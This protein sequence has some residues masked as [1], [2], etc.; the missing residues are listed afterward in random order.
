MEASRAAS[1]EL[2]AAAASR[3]RAWSSLHSTEAGLSVAVSGHDA[4]HGTDAL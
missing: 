2:P 4:A 3:S 1:S